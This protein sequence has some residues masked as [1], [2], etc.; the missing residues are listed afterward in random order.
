MIDEMSK[1]VIR[2]F[3]KICFSSV[4]SGTGAGCH[5]NGYHKSCDDMT[6]IN[7]G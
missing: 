4:V 2:I 5:K 3:R 1:K 6:V 7:L